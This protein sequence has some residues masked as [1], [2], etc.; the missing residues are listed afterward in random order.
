MLIPEEFSLVGELL[1]TVELKHQSLMEGL[2]SWFV[3]VP[4]ACPLG[5]EVYFVPALGWKCQEDAVRVEVVVPIL[6][7]VRR[8][9][10][11]KVS[12]MGSRFLWE[13]HS[14]RGARFV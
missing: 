11:C 6:H 4:E 2:V 12:V 13:V 1:E 14:S 9:G 5:V 7:V 8:F 10:G 3:V